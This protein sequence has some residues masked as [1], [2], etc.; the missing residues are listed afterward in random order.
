M[1]FKEYQELAYRT[2][3]DQTELAKTITPAQLEL[4]NWALGL[5]GEAGEVADYLKKCV[6]HGH[7]IEREKLVK[8]LGDVCW[9]LA[10]LAS[11]LGVP[12]E[13]IASKNIDKLRRRYPEGFSSGHS[14]NRPSDE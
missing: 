7:P 2:A 14:I 4:V 12:L 5:T 6:F 11:A 1:D 13:E 10:G 9:Y 8:E 3:G